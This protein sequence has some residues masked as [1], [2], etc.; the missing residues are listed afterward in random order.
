MG[1]IIGVIFAT[2]VVT[3]MSLDVLKWL[4]IIVVT[5]TGGIMLYEGAQM[6]NKEE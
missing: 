6:K 5:V 3:S 2:Q 1:G 4:V